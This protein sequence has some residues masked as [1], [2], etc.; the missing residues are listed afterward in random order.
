MKVGRTPCRRRRAARLHAAALCLAATLLAGCGGAQMTST[1]RYQVLDLDAESL[2]RGGL[3]LITPS[4]VTGQEQDK[5]ALA[6]IFADVF[7]HTRPD[8]PLVRLSET[9]SV[10]NRGNLTR[11]YER[12]LAEAS[13]TGVLDRRVLEQVA[14]HTGM[15]YLAH[16]KLAGFEQQSLQRWS[17]LGVR[18]VETKR[19]NIRLF[20]QI[21]DSTEGSVVWEG[22]EELIYAMDTASEK[23]VTLRTV[24]EATTANLLAGLPG[25]PSPSPPLAEEH[26]HRPR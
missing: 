25:A 17:L 22:T 26:E 13:N 10:L 9:L 3:A 5:Q 14:R 21:W 20:L 12:M 23:V 8:V 16:L 7:E 6:L 18:M 1:V 4:T 24:V 15:R 19:A 2:R 11:G